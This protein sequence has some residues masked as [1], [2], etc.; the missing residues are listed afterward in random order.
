MSEDATAYPLQNLMVELFEATPEQIREAVKQYGTL[1][2]R[3][4]MLGVAAS[5]KEQSPLYLGYPPGIFISYKWEGEP[6]KKYVAALATHLRNRGYRAYLDVDELTADADNYT[7]VPQFIV[8]LQ[9]CVYYV[10]LLTKNA[11]DFI[12]AR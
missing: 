12:D 11:A 1:A 9:D 7:A 6:M 4:A 2:V 3:I 5:K 8:S 10:L